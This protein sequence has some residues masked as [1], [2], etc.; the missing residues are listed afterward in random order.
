MINAL[1]KITKAAEVLNKRYLHEINLSRSPQL[2]WVSLTFYVCSLLPGHIHIFVIF[3][4]AALFGLLV[5]ERLASLVFFYW[6]LILYLVFY[7]GDVEL[8]G[9]VIIIAMLLLIVF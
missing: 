2:G 8:R 6:I 9:C 7:S 5:V 1:I 4:S 3:V